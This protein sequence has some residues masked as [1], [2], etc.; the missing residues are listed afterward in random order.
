LPDDLPF[1]DILVTAKKL[2]EENDPSDLEA[3][4]KALEKRE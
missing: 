3:E 4:V 2:Y 1:E